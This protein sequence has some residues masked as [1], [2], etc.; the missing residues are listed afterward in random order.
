MIKV[1]LTGGNG[2]IGQ[3]VLAELNKHNVKVIAITR[4]LQRGMPEI[5]NGHWVQMDL[6]QPQ[7]NVYEILDKPDL[8]IHLAWQGLPNYY[9]LHHFE[10]ELPNQYAFLKEMISQGLL[11]LIVSGSCFEY[12]MQSGALYEH[13]ETRPNNSYGFAKDS[14]RKQLQ[15]LQASQPFNLTWARLFYTYGNGQSDASLIP[16]LKHAVR[17][18]DKIFNMSGGEQLRDYLPVSE[19]AKIMVFLALKQENI[20]LINI[21][22]GTPVSVRKFVE[23]WIHNEQWKINLNLGYYPYPDYE[24]MAF[25]GDR[26]RLMHLTEVK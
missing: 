23:Q 3:H 5:N 26:T 16:Q 10:T 25:W 8:L 13:M 24:P 4:K 17:R 11:S 22:S 9:S 7:S 19:I 15:Y 1:A 14:L 6:C 21:C 18:G 20:G 12:G 2:F